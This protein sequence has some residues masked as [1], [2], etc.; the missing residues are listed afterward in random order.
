MDTKVS[1]FFLC[2]SLYH[3]FI[4]SYMKVSFGHH[5]NQCVGY[6]LLFFYEVGFKNNKIL[7]FIEVDKS[8]CNFFPRCNYLQ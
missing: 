1:V 3:I 6:F 4:F 7:I 5:S 8:L 2:E